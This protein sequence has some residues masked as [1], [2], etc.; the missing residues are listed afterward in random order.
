MNKLPFK[1]INFWMVIILALMCG[2]LQAQNNY[3]RGKHIELA[4]EGWEL[5]PDGSYDLHF[6]YHNENWEEMPNIPIGENN[7][8]SPGEADR[9]QPTFFQPRRNRF[10]FTVN[11]PSDFGDSELVWTITANG[12][13]RKAYGSLIPDFVVNKDL[14][15]S[16]TGAF[17]GAGGSADGD[18]N[19][20]PTVTILEGGTRYASVNEPLTLVARVEDDG[21][22]KTR[23]G[24]ETR[25]PSSEWERINRP[26]MISSVNK[27]NG[28]HL[29]WIVYRAEDGGDGNSVI[30]D[31]EQVKV[32]EDTRPSNNSPWSLYW[33]P[34]EVPED[35]N[36][37]TEVTFKEAG[38]YVLMAR[39]DDGGLFHDQY[40]T[41]E[42]RDN[43]SMSVN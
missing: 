30:F 29:S 12:E 27:I 24:P 2:T 3:N 9:G 21:Y 38:T 40:L 10:V 41:V 43:T 20:K 39:A 7:Y 26:P 31:P 35:G 5:M 8:F 32:W 1:S 23:R 6:G 25:S 34:P 15:Q 37:V 14:I 18:M 33:V 11:V 4:Y 17:G 19:Q 13:T 42:V 28:L 36:Y 22:P 16:E